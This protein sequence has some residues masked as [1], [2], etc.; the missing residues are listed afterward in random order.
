MP[1]AITTTVAVAA[2][3]AMTDFTNAVLIAVVVAR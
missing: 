1:P 3:L 2:T